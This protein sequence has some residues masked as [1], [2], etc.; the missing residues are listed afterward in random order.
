[1]LVLNVVQGEPN[2]FVYF[3]LIRVFF[4]NYGL[5]LVH[6][7]AKARSQAITSLF[8]VLKALEGEPKR[9]APVF[10]SL[11]IEPF[12]DLLMERSA[13]LSPLLFGRMLGDT[14]KLQSHLVVPSQAYAN[15][16]DAIAKQFSEKN[17]AKVRRM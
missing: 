7:H 13:T 3:C 11:L 15:A 14:S 2:Q 5:A 8:T 10:Q 4:A 16:L 17:F 6:P 12:F 9:Q 1:M